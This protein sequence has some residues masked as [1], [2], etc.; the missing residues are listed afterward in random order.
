MC[1]NEKT[2]ELEGLAKVLEKSSLFH[3]K[4]ICSDP[5][6]YKKERNRDKMQILVQPADAES[7]VAAEGGV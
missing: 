2:K 7:T 4:P 6:N 1:L 5:G 3:Q